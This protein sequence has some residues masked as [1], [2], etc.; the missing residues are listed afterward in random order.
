MH[1]RKLHSKTFQTWLLKSPYRRRRPPVGPTYAQ[2]AAVHRG[3]SIP[4]VGTS[5]SEHGCLRA[6][7]SRLANRM[8]LLQW[9]TVAAMISFTKVPSHIAQCEESEP[10][11][12]NPSQRKPFSFYD[13]TINSR[14]LAGFG[15]RLG[16]RSNR[17]KPLR[18]FE[19]VKMATDTRK[20]RRVHHVCKDDTGQQMDGCA[21]DVYVGVMNNGRCTRECM[22]TPF[23][24]LKSPR[25]KI[26][27]YKLR[28]T[29]STPDVPNC[30]RSKGSAP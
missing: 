15:P 29:L 4:G 5:T 30:C 21:G 25:C 3:T 13:R 26:E 20:N 11:E 10:P 2:P 17:R 7:T 28:L 19:V 22:E 6:C 9:A 1:T 18:S 12:W 27:N 16:F 14:V 24:L 23:S 8:S